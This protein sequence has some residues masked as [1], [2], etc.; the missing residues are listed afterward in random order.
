[1]SQ[2]QSNSPSD[3]VVEGYSPR[4]AGAARK[5]L[6]VEGELSDDPSDR[7]GITKFGISLRFLA[8]EGAFDEDG[9]GKADFDL[10]MDGDIDG[11]DIRLLTPSNAVFLFYRCFWQRLGIE[12]LPIPAPIGEMVFDQA[13]NGGITTSR[14]LLQRAINSCLLLIPAS[15][16]KVAVLKVDGAIGD[17]TVAAM[18]FVLAWP[19]VGAGGLATAFRDAARERY[20]AI[21]R[22]WPDQQKYLNGWIARADR[23]GK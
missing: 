21:V 1:M 10:D 12:T 9:D 14:K 7:G 6:G 2:P 15:Q 11:H 22:R 20:R 17:V 18:R 5:L 16:C 13:V 4:Y 8:A 3:I 23:L 19:S